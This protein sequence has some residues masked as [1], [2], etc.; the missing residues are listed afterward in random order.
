MPCSRALTCK[1][2]S[3]GAKRDVPGRSKPYDV[4][5][6]EWNAVHKPHLAVKQKESKLRREVD[7]SP[8]DVAGT[9][10][11]GGESSAGKKKKS[12]AAASGSGK[13]G[14]SS[15][16]SSMN[17]GAAGTGADSNGTATPGSELA[18]LI[19]AAQAS[20]ARLAAAPSRRL[21]TAL[22]KSGN[23]STAALPP[24]GIPPAL[25][26]PPPGSNGVSARKPTAA[27]LRQMGPR[28]LP[29]EAGKTLL[30]GRRRE[31]SA[32]LNNLLREALTGEAR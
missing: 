26:A 10:K 3:V 16:S 1:S 17:A 25:L 24:S 7:R 29:R 13:K 11:A 8:S 32:T 30:Y 9:P 15:S 27:Q 31:E 18:W 21:T 2:H 4:L 22:A 28:V 5:F 19:S 20:R 6:A 12:G 14:K 23:S